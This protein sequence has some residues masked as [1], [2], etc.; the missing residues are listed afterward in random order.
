[1]GRRGLEPGSLTGARAPLPCTPQL[2]QQ[3][4]P[5]G[6]GR[7]TGIHGVTPEDR[8]SARLPPKE[9]NRM[10]LSENENNR[11]TLIL[12]SCLKKE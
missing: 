2:P 5:A 4:R 1:M 3:E 10:F 7:A 12:Q 6:A 11:T 9:S 8:T